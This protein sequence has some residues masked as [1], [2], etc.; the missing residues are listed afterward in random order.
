MR[1]RY[2][3]HPW[4]ADP[5]AAVATRMTK[6]QAMQ[7]TETTNADTRKERSKQKRKR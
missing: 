2:P 1:G 3:K 7:S 6:K 5:L 4:P